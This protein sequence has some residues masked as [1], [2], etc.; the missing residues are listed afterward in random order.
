M[1]IVKVGDQPYVGMELGVWE[2]RED[3]VKCAE[4]YIKRSVN[5]VNWVKREEGKWAEGSNWLQITEIKINQ[6]LY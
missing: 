1:Y 4:R 2:S 5:F 3:A 6:D